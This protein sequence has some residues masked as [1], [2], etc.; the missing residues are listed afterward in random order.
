MEQR[1]A[2]QPE[3]GPDVVQ[4]PLECV[5]ER[6]ALADEPLAMV[7]EQPQIEFWALQ[8]GSWEGFQAFA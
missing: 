2:R 1:A 4:V 3:F 8:V 6:D 7:D 5:V